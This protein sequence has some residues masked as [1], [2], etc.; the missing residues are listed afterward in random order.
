[1]WEP[2][3]QRFTLNRHAESVLGWTTAD[4][5]NG[6]FMSKVYPDA[7][8]RAKV[9]EYMQSLKSGW[10]EWIGT[11]KNGDLVPIE[12]ANVRLSDDTMIGIGVDL[13][14]RKQAEQALRES[15]SLYRAIARNFP[16]G[17][18][19]V[20]DHDLR[21]R[22][23][24]GQAMKAL[25]LTRKGLEGKTIWEA[26]DEE[27]CKI[28]EQRYPKVLAGE[29]L[30]FE[31]SLKGRIFFSDYVPIH[32]EHGQVI[33]GMVVSHDITERKQT[34]EALR[35]AVE[36]YE[37]QVRLFEGVTSTTPD[38]VYLFDL[39]GRF[40]YANRR[41]LEV[42][43]MTLPEVTGKT[44]RELGYEQWHHDMHM[45]E[46]AQVIETKNPI[47]GEV[48]FKAPITGIFGIY[49][50]IFTP[51]IDSDGK[52]ELIA[53]TT[54]DITERKQTEQALK[55]LTKN[56][57][58]RVA[59]RTAVAE[60]RARQ[61]QQLA[62]EL[63]NAEDK[64]RKQIALT[65]HDDLQQ[66]LSALRFNLYT[67]LPEEMI[68]DEIKQRMQQYENLINQA[69]QKCRSLSHDLSPP[70][71]HQSGL[72][73][74][75]D[76][77]AN[78]M[79]AKHGQQVTLKLSSDAESDSPALASILF[80][81]VREL[82]FNAL[83]H[84]GTA[85]AIIEAGVEGDFIRISVKDHGKGCDVEEVKSRSGDTPGFGLFNI[86]ERINFLGGRFE[87]DSIPGNGCCATLRVPKE[88]KMAV[89]LQ[90]E[91]R[92][93]AAPVK[94][95]DHQVPIQT[96]Q[97][98]IMIVDDH[99]SMRQ[100]MAMLLN[101]HEDFVLLAEAANG[102]EAVQMAKQYNPDVVLMD[103]S[104]PGM[105]GIETTAII[106]KDQPDIRIVGLSMH[107]DEKTRERMIA[108][109][110]S[111]YISKVA[112]VNAIIEVIRSTR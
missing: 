64:E 60:E 110:A 18:I 54:R 86:E 109:G 42:W 61:L 91:Q 78:E 72:F 111:A 21:F 8:Y 76:W 51:V 65:L 32:N 1:M 92:P 16:E 35:K 68:D 105:D 39:Q 13:R 20:F 82:L 100:G 67:L 31:T 37:R 79:K 102:L 58:T 103:V 6:D 12:W 47:K 63:S 112:P 22:I 24:D 75:L 29:S 34:E 25:D 5:N 38:F 43:G 40:L 56:L 10:H 19:Y 71:L 81:S 70:V 11:T 57:E 104:M 85:T 7:E 99:A 45:R 26:T 66:H 94:I 30:H 108:A 87:I 55:D 84:S 73:A 89:N 9:S 48:P 62:L 95:I 88:H 97:L 41:L 28:L 14:D 69:I 4:A 83:K 17:A 93:P 90:T 2:Q 27:T 36:G 50:Y 44:C 23:A 46:I 53:G 74:A 59:E 33:A 15:E 77:L 101:A 49:E 106:K 98:R 3:L 96:D 80:R 107:E 52:V